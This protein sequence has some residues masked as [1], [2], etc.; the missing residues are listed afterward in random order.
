[1]RR[2]ARALASILAASVRFLSSRRKIQVRLS[3]CLKTLSSFLSPP[4]WN[5]TG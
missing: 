5:G 2:E 4:I 1:M 3:P